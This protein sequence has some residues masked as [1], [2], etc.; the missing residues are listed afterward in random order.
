MTGVGKNLISILTAIRKYNKNTRGN[1]GYW[2]KKIPFKSVKPIITNPEVTRREFLSRSQKILSE[3]NMQ[4][5]MAN[6]VTAMERDQMRANAWLTSPDTIKKAKAL[7]RSTLGRIGATYTKNNF[8]KGSFEKRLS[9]A[10][11]TSTKGFKEDEWSMLKI[12]AD[13]PKKMIKSNL[14]KWSYWREQMHK[15][16]GHRYGTGSYHHSAFRIPKSMVEYKPITRID[17]KDFI[18]LYDGE[19]YGVLSYIKELRRVTKDTNPLLKA[20]REGLYGK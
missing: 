14:A 19:E 3:A 6:T 4:R 5:K 2:S 11:R 8:K 1:V 12:T 7:D 20:F 18:N 16:Y 13:T 9:D 17:G 10:M 15:Y